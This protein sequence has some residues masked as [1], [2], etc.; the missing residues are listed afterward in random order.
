M[1]NVT[2]NHVAILTYFLVSGCCSRNYLAHVFVLLFV[3]QAVHHLH[4]V[5]PTG[6]VVDL[7]EDFLVT[8]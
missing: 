7:Q 8:Y 5:L 4:Q 3:C 2:W 6:K 1:Q